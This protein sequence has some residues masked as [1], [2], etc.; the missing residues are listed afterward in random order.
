MDVPV[1]PYAPPQSSLD[2]PADAPDNEG[3]LPDASMGARF[4]NLL[5]DLAGRLLLTFLV[6]AVMGLAGLTDISG[7]ADT[8]IAILC[9]LGYYVGFEA[10]L[11]R[12]PGKLITGTRVV[13]KRGGKPTLGQIL[14]R[15]LARFVPFE[16]FSFLGRLPTGWHDR[17]SRTRVVKVRL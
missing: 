1:N 4:L 16:P 6:G 17:W 9:M 2:R 7:T 14:G 15:T 12:T 11:G 13:T 8:A 5:I 10:L 3:Y